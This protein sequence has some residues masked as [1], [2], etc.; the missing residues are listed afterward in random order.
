MIQDVVLRV[1]V[2]TP[3]RR[4]ESPV[5]HQCQIPLDLHQP[6][7]DRPG[8]I[9]GTCPVCGGWHFLRLDDNG[10]ARLV[11]HLPLGDLDSPG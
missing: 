8:E 7:P 5:C 10:H 2:S 6:V 4:T 3:A 9:L 1:R 11:A